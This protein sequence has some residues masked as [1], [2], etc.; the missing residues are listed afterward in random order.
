MGGQQGVAVPVRPAQVSLRGATAD[1]SVCQCHRRRTPNSQPTNQP[2]SRTKSKSSF[3]FRQ[4][5]MHHPHCMRAAHLRAPWM[6]LAPAL[7]RPARS[8]RCS[9]VRVGAASLPAT[10]DRPLAPLPSAQHHITTQSCEQAGSCG[11]C[12][13]V[14]PGATAG[15][16]PRRTE[17]VPWPSRGVVA[18]DSTSLVKTADEVVA[19]PWHV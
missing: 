17:P 3:T 10:G 6:L 7:R 11:I 1:D 16:H 4:P 2:T 13:F 19:I 15:H 14:S 12:L 18:R 9:P 5:C 8:N